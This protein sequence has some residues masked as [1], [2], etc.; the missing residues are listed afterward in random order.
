MTPSGK[1]DR[2]ALT[3]RAADMP[4]DTRPELDAA[5]APPVTSTEK[6]LI[7]IV[8]EALGL[9]RV[10]MDDDF[11]D[12]GGHSLLAMRIIGRVKDVLGVESSIQVLY[13][14]STV[15]GFMAALASQGSVAESAESA[16]TRPVAMRAEE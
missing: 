11:F 1:L 2:K 10:G 8:E 6:V 12:L 13:E 7:A 9:D 16:L 5:Y 3:E 14:A 15:R 4:A